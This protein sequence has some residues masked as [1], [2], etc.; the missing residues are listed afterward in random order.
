M[1][2]LISP[3]RFLE[4]VLVKMLLTWLST[5]RLLIISWA[6]ISWLVRPVAISSTIS[7]SRSERSLRPVAVDPAAREGSSGRGPWLVRSGDPRSGMPCSALITHFRQAS[8]A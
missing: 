3:T 7:N 1:A 8:A 4:P 5:V 6:A 2:Q